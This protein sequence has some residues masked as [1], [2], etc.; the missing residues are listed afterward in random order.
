MC[1]NLM[2]LAAGLALCRATPMKGREGLKIKIPTER[3]QTRRLDTTRTNV[4]P[5]GPYWSNAGPLG[6]RDPGYAY[7]RRSYD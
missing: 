3:P 5:L 1:P 2:Q 6:S 4:W 7:L